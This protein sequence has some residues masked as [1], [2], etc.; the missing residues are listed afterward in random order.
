[1]TKRDV[2]IVGAGL[3]GQIIARELISRGRLVTLLDSCKENA[4]SRPAACLMR[5]SWFSSL[6]K[7]I[8]KPALE[9]LDRNYGLHDLQFRVGI[10]KIGGI[11]MGGVH[12]VDPAQ[13][14][15]LP[16]NEC[17]VISIGDREII[18]D[19]GMIQADLIIVAAGVWT[20]E[21]INVPGLIGKAGCAYTWETPECIKFQ[22]FISAYR[23]YCQVV[24]FRR[25]PTELWCGDGTA[26]LTKN[27]SKDYDNATL[28]RCTKALKMDGTDLA[29]KAT[30]IFGIRPYMKKTK[31]CHLEQVTPNLW[32]ATGGAK[33][34]TL[35]A[36][37]CAHRISEATC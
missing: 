22:P 2:V 32:V 26:I 11:K 4:G 17:R 27:W 9:L 33:N 16:V 5:P 18:T 23:P 7:D 34:G 6:G 21:L 28:D 19:K 1:M 25:S 29:K 14:L 13:V 20:S 31:V 3:F 15:S 8:T 12:W 36:A 24:A 35:A 30:R 10:T 37:W